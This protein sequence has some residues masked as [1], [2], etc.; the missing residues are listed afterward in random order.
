MNFAYVMDCISAVIRKALTCH[1]LLTLSGYSY[2]IRR[3]EHHFS[4]II[5]NK[6]IFVTCL[7]FQ[8]CFHFVSLVNVGRGEEKISLCDLPHPPNP[9]RG[10]ATGGHCGSQQKPP[11][12]WLPI[13]PC[14][15]NVMRVSRKFR[16]LQKINIIIQ[17]LL[18][19]ISLRL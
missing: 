1:T 5:V 12:Q 6:I 17:I 13:L 7:Q 14:L 16:L 10:W 15:L 3:G 4:L 2:L 18:L 19:L 9:V 8:L 11:P